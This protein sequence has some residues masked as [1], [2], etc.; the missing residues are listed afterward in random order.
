M[1]TCID[2]QGQVTRGLGQAGFTRA[3][4]GESNFG[5]G[6]IVVCSAASRKIQP[7]LICQSKIQLL[8]RLFFGKLTTSFFVWSIATVCL[9][10]TNVTEEDTLGPVCAHSGTSV[11]LWALGLIRRWRYGGTEHLVWAIGA[12]GAAVT[13]QT[14]GNTAAT[15]FTCKVS[16]GGQ[17]RM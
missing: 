6:G 17:H 14:P 5:C 16:W 1:Q 11:T 10:I 9:S 15:I 4:I 8:A 7:Q 12:V 2:V 3:G 13:H